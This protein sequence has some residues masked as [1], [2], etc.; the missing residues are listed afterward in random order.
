MAKKK[1]NINEITIGGVNQKELTGFTRQFATLQ[2]AGLNTLRSL[3]ILM[4]IWVHIRNLFPKNFHDAWETSV[5]I[6]N[7]I[8]GNDTSGVQKYAELHFTARITT[9]DEK[10]RLKKN[11]H[12]IAKENKEK[13]KVKV[14]IFK[15]SF[16]VNTP[17][18]DPFIRNLVKP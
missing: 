10:K 7:I 17:H 2:N 9:E 18:T 4:N 13:G 14:E 6:D 8:T 3:E 5:N 1:F 16:L 11:I 15:E 12:Y